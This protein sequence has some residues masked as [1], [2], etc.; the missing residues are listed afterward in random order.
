VTWLLTAASALVTLAA[1]A[2][3]IRE[4]LRE[5]RPQLVSWLGW[6]ALLVTGASSALAAG[7][8]PAAVYILACAAMCVAVIVLAARRGAWSFS[9]LDRVCLAGVA[10]GLALLI[11]DRSPDLA[12]AVTVAVDAAAYVPTAVHAWRKPGE[13]PWI[14]FA[15]WSAGAA[16]SLAAAHVLV[17]TAVAYPAYLLAG[18][19]AVTV[20]I[21]VR[22][23]N[24]RLSRVADC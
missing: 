18:D 3:Y 23:R 2:V 17:F 22:L 13:E 4:A 10:G 20:M 15:G 19:S 6:T 12:T 14:A 7:Q 8:V 11:A 21:L 1:G 9:L 24:K 5:A 16:L